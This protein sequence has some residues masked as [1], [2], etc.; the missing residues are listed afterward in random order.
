MVRQMTVDEILKEMEARKERAERISV[1]FAKDES[2]V[3]KLS[4]AKRGNTGKVVAHD[5]IDKV[6]ALTLT[7]EIKKT[8]ASVKRFAS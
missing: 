2:P 7:E 6:F 3:R 1:A 5:S 4:E 8:K